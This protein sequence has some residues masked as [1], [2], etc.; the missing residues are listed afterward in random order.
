MTN[1]LVIHRDLSLKGG[2]EAVCMNVIEALQQKHSVT[3]ITTTEPDI[4]ELNE[5]YHTEVC[6]AHLDIKVFSPGSTLTSQLP[7]DIK[8]LRWSLFQRYVR[9]RGRRYDKVINT[10]ASDIAFPFESIQYIHNPRPFEVHSPAKSNVGRYLFYKACK[11]VSGFDK[12]LISKDTIL[13]NSGWTSE[14]ILECYDCS[15]EVVYPPVAVE[16]FYDV[17]WE[18]RESGFVSIG[19]I[20]P[21]K[22]ILR[23][24]EIISE[25]RRR[26]H[27]IHYH[28]V[29]PPGDN[30]YYERV[31][32]AS[33][34]H[35]YIHL[36]GKVSR[37]K[38]VDFV[39][40]HRYGI[41]GK[42]REHFGIAVA[43]M[44]A[45][46]MIPFVPDGGG[47]CEIVGSCPKLIYGS[48][49]EAAEEIHTFMTQPEK[50]KQIRNQIISTIPFTRDGFKNTLRTYISKST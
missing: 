10:T 2:A 20:E 38:L 44:V 27:D 1:I 35:D 28:I 36:E 24:V 49:D 4:T 46:G 8:L 16:E 9:I 43:E 18:Q 40:T 5:Y 22:N 41:H 30:S 45:G 7:V 21:S 47:Q 31:V 23:N 33:Q 11:K 13:T 26:G 3:L 12:N 32:E 6:E 42:S 29:G 50:A 14:R 48:T 37:G 19:R 17:P 39:C 15:S 25:V 34:K